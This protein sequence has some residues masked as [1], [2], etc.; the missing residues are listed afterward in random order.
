MNFRE[1]S[2]GKISFLP[3]LDLIFLYVSSIS[4]EVQP[5]NSNLGSYATPSLTF[6]GGGAER[7]PSG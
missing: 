2:Q 3:N 1:L 4:I 6:R 7:P 5:L